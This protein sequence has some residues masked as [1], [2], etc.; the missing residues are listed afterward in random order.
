MTGNTIYPSLAFS[1]QSFE[2]DGSGIKQVYEKDA[3]IFAAAIGVRVGLEVKIPLAS[4]TSFSYKSFPAKSFLGNVTIL[5]DGYHDLIRPVETNWSWVY[6]EESVTG[7]N[8]YYSLITNLNQQRYW[9]DFATFNE[10][11]FVCDPARID[12]FDFVGLSFRGVAVKPFLQEEYRLTIQFVSISSWTDACGLTQNPRG[13]RSNPLNTE[14]SR[15]GRYFS[16]PTVLQGQVTPPPPPPVTQFPDG[17][18]PSSPFPN[19][20]KDATGGREGQVRTWQYEIRYIDCN[21]CGAASP[22]QY[23]YN[24][25]GTFVSDT[26]EVKAGVPNV[27]CPNCP[28]LDIYVGGQPLLGGNI[29]SV[30]SIV[31]ID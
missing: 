19:G 2:F 21:N 12:G 8:F 14:S 9:K 15:E 13:S 26:W 28:A 22:V 18:S 3:L 6:E 10:L 29:N 25:F 31:P 20:G 23:N 1:S 16:D 11:E 27:F 30:L 5:R 17:N 7:T 4:Q 24:P